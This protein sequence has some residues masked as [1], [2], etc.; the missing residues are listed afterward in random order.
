ML[1]GQFRRQ[2][3]MHLLIGSYES[4]LYGLDT[5]FKLQFATSMHVGKVTAVAILKDKFASAGNDENVKVYKN[6]KLLF[7]ADMG[8]DVTELKFNKNHLLCAAGK[9][10]VI[11]DSDQII[12]ELKH[13]EDIKSFSIHP[14]NTFLLSMTQTHL[15]LFDLIHGKKI[16]KEPLKKYLKA[17]LFPFSIQFDAT[18]DY[19]YIVSDRHLLIFQTDDCK[20]I[21]TFSSSTI[22]TS[23]SVNT[24]CTLGFDNGTICII[25]P[26]HQTISM[27]SLFT[28]RVKG[29]A[30]LNDTITAV[31][32]NGLVKQ[33]LLSSADIGTAED[34]PLSCYQGVFNYSVYL[35]DYTVLNSYDL[36]C[37]VTCFA[38]NE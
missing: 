12:K 36:N 22:I 29:L 32:C 17:S 38:L 11:Y 23:M 10:L 28:T 18:G 30:I 4:H 33:A 9:I 35:F 13:T 25:D 19:F 2:L 6:N 26:L 34:T 16:V 21:N 24:N 3:Q 14:T 7:T 37:R 1:K 15:Y 20:C 31:D 8:G 27:S 5:E